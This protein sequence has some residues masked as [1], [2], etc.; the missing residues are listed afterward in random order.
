MLDSLSPNGRPHQ[1]FDATIS[2]PRCRAYCQQPLQPTVLVLEHLQLARLRHVHAA[3]R[4]LPLLERRAAHAVLATHV[5]R[6]RS[7]FTLPQDRNHLLLGKSA[8]LYLR[9]S[10]ER[11]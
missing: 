4:R 11:L 9:S 2:A 1:L 10:H 7:S 8:A 6:L 5:R 3:I